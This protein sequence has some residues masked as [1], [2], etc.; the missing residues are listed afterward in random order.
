MIVISPNKPQS[1]ISD[2]DGRHPVWIIIMAEVSMQIKDIRL[3]DK[4][5]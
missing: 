2:I 4:F 1:I 3:N 5:I